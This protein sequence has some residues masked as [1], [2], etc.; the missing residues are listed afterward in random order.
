MLAAVVSCPHRQTAQESKP[1]DLTEHTGS[2]PTPS[3]L[4]AAE[5]G[6]TANWMGD[7]SHLDITSLYPAE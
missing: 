6:H 5:H 2:Q 3:A 1:G 4:G 7:L